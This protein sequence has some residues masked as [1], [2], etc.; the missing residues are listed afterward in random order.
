MSHIDPKRFKAFAEERSHKDA[1]ASN[2]TGKAA[3]Q[4]AILINGGAATA[5]LAYLAKEHI[6]IHVLHIA[7]WCLTG[8][9]FGIVC[10]AFMMYFRLHALDEYGVRWRY[11]A[12]PESGHNAERHR[13]KAF[14]ISSRANWLFVASMLFFVATSFVMAWAIANSAPATC[15]MTFASVAVSAT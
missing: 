12:H 10:G 1:E 13:Q 15:L 4:A 11:E 6:D 3:A 8:Y 2:D 14:K 5:V 7:A 9:G